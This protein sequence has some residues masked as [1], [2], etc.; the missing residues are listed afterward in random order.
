MD[1]LIPILILG[2]LGL[3]FGIGLAVASQRFAVKKND[4]R[5]EKITELLPGA[6]CGACGNAGCEGFAEALLTG[7]VD[8]ETCKVSEVGARQKIAE[9]LGKKIEDKTALVATL[10]CNGGRR[11]Q[12]R[13]LYKGIQDC[14]GANLLLGGQ[15]SCI[16]GCLGFGSCVKACPFGAITMSE[17]DIPKVDKDKCRAC[18]RCVEV[19]P[20]RLFSLIPVTSS[21]YVACSS[22]DTG[23]DTRLFCS[24]G[25]IACGRCEQVCPVGAIQVLDKLAVIDYSKCNSCKECVKACP[26]KTIHIRE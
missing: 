4:P 25:C 23:K 13:F 9:L 18:N 12:D 20:K 24:V 17:E 3:F 11:A 26:M 21:V 8:I 2:I 10:H 6:N 7:K 16:Y 1:I 19:C 15:K 14:I 22:H 5:L